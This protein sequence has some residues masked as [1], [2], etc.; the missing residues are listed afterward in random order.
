MYD[1]PRVKECVAADPR[2]I[3][4]YKYKRKILDVCKTDLQTYGPK[5]YL[6]ISTCCLVITLQLDEC[7]NPFSGCEPIIIDINQNIRLTILLNSTFGNACNRLTS[8]SSLLS[9]RSILDDL[10]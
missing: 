8:F 9:A 1:L 3:N 6:T 5:K 10:S 4:V 7:F 2:I